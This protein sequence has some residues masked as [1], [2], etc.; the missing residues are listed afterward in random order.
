[1][2]TIITLIQ[3]RPR[4]VTNIKGQKSPIKG[5]HLNHALKFMM[6]AKLAAGE[7]SFQEANKK[8]R[9]Q[10]LSKTVGTIYK[11]LASTG[12]VLDPSTTNRC[13]SL[14]KQVDAN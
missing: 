14:L 13:H 5:R 3:L 4:G 2:I 7:S 6:A 9:H 8:G 1:M 10:A 11:L 12:G